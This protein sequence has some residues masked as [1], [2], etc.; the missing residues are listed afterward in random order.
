MC[1]SW[2]IS[3]IK[4]EWPGFEGSR[5]KMMGPPRKSSRR[6]GPGLGKQSIGS[7]TTLDQPAWKNTTSVKLGKSPLD[8]KPQIKVNG[9][10]TKSTKPKKETKQVIMLS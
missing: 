1:Q 9:G 7:R 5:H 3:E 8:S 6:L 4:L 10:S 2:H